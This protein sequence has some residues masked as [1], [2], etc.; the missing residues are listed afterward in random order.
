MAA[1]LRTPNQGVQPTKV[2]PYLNATA[3]T[4]NDSADL[5][6]VAYALVCAVSGVV[7]VN[8]YG[9][10]TS[11]V[12]PITAGIPLPLLVTRVLAASTTATG[13]VALD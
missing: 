10:Q 7:E 4:P 5:T 2:G 12:V 9:G 13:I 11:V 3:V 1:T 8:T 6:Y